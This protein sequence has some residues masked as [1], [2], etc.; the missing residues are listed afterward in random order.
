MRAATRSIAEIAALEVDTIRPADVAGALGI[1]PYA[2]NCSFK[3][4][5]PMFPGFMSGNR[6]K[7]WRRAFLQLVGWEQEGTKNEHGVGIQGNG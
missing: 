4:G 3:A 6:V 2:I 1:S 5:R 7:I